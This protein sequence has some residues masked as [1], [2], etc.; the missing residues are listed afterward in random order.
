MTSDE[1][2]DLIHES[3]SAIA[4]LAF[5]FL[6]FLLIC[7]FWLNV[8]TIGITLLTL[9][10]LCYHLNNYRKAKYLEDKSDYEF[11]TETIR[12]RGREYAKNEYTSLLREYER[13]GGRFAKFAKSKKPTPV[14]SFKR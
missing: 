4:A 8:W 5:W 9:V 6:V 1:R 11:I 13:G 10:V 14:N 12:D 2:D 3:G 7:Y